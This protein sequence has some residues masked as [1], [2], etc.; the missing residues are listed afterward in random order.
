VM[1]QFLKNTPSFSTV[2]EVKKTTKYN[3]YIYLA[4]LEILSLIDYLFY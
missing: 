3:G 2:F 1:F 4:K